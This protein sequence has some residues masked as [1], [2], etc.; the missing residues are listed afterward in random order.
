MIH[1]MEVSHGFTFKALPLHLVAPLKVLVGK[2]TAV[3][4]PMARAY[5]KVARGTC[6]AQ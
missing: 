4:P 5:S 2:H 6:M 1:R 3:A